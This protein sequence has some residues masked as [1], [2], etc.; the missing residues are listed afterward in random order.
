MVAEAIADPV[1]ETESLAS[2]PES[3]EAP[4]LLSP[5]EDAPASPG[6]ETPEPKGAA[7]ESA[8]PV[9]KSEL[10]P[11]AQLSAQEQEAAFRELRDKGKS[12]GLSA[13][14]I[15]RRDQLEQAITHRQA[16]TARRTNEITAEN[17]RQWQET[18]RKAEAAWAKVVNLFDTDDPVVSELR[19]TRMAEALSAIEQAARLTD[20]NEARKFVLDDLG[21]SPEMRRTV[22]SYT[23]PVALY[24]AHVAALRQQL[25]PAPDR[26]VLTKAQLQKEKD[27]AAK[28]EV[29]KWKRANPNAVSPSVSTGG[30]AAGSTGWTTERWMAQTP[31][32]RRDHP[33]IEMDI[34]RRR[35][36]R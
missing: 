6:E 21:D 17:N 15:E 14:E 4:E 12:E 16:E 32:F 29:D 8:K 35:T 34:I 5:Q 22:F 3:Q 1:S 20:L 28:A 30:P 31:Q 36:G 10:P 26:V 27:S 7:D 25:S 23:D 9:A 2:T 18:V 33:E 13:Q 24:R 11:V 19:D